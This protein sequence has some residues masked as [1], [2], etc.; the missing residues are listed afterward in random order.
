MNNDGAMGGGQF[1][2]GF[3]AP[4]EL[5]RNSSQHS[6]SSSMSSSIHSELSTMKGKR[7]VI[8]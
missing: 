8:E 7:W 3:T 6:A 5:V 1:G 4:K 2:P